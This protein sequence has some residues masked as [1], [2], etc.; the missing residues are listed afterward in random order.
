MARAAL[1]W[2][3]KDLARRARIDGNTVVRFENGSRKSNETTMLVIKQAFEAAGIRFEGGGVFP[4]EEAS[5]E[6]P[7]EEQQSVEESAASLLA[8]EEG[9]RAS[10]GKAK[11][12]DGRRSRKHEQR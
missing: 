8:R 1:R 10:K 5:A 3:T 6:E 7:A 12:S 9:L 4:P 11:F 2:T